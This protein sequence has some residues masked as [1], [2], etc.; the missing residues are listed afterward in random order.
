MWSFCTWLIPLLLA[1]GVWR[2]VLHR[3]PPH[4]ETSLWSMVFPVGMY[5]VAARELGEAA[6]WRWMT[7]A[8][9][10]EA[11]AAQAVW[12]TV[13]AGMLAAPFTAL[14]APRGQ[15]PSDAM[16][17]RQFVRLAG[18]GPGSRPQD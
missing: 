2:H 10:D 3:V 7:A 12:A 15:E 9:A 8:G 6:G 11:R 14:D 4:Y 1:L 13:F 18:C 5:G 16:Y 17:V